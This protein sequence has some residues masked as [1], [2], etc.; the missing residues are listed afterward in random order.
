MERKRSLLWN[1]FSHIPNNPDAVKCDLC[2][3]TYSTKG[4]SSTNLKKHLMTRHRPSYDNLFSS[5][6]PITT[7]A[8]T[9]QP[10][11]PSVSTSTQPS[12]SQNHCLSENVEE[13]V[14]E[15]SST[16]I[17]TLSLPGKRQ[18]HISTFIKQRFNVARE[19]KINEL[20]MKMVVKDLQPL[21]VVEDSG[22]KDLVNFLEPNYKMPSRYMLS[23]S[24]LDI[25]FSFV[26]ERLNNE[27]KEAKYIALTT[28]GWTSRAANSY[29]A[30]TAHYILKESWELRSALL[31][32]FECQER[33][34]AEYL[35]NTIR[36]VT[37]SFDINEK[38]FVCVTDNAANMKAAVRLGGWEHFP[39]VAHTLN[40]MVRTG[41]T[42][43]R[44]ILKKIKAIV[45][46]FHRSSVAT[47][48]LVEIQEQLRPGQ[49]PL[50]M[51]LDVVTRW[52][53]TLDMIERINILQEPLG[54]A[55]GLL[56]N[57][58]PNLTEEEWILLPELI[59]ILKPFK[60]LTE[61]VSSQ[62][63]VSISKILAATKSVKRILNALDQT[64]M[65]SLSKDLVE[66]LIREYNKR[67]QNSSFHPILSKAALLDPRFKKASFACDLSYESGEQALQ[68]ELEQNPTVASI[69]IN[70]EV[71]SDPP[72]FRTDEPD[73]LWADFDTMTAASSSNIAAS[74]VSIRQYMDEKNINRK[75]NPLLWWK[76]RKIL[77]PEL[78]DLALKYLCIP[79]SSVPSERIFSKSGQILSE[80]RASLKPKR[81]EKILFLNVNQHLMN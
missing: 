64:A 63:E 62:K 72:T 48:K 22:F 56:H 67:F 47:K 26:K 12:T 3:S 8:P 61:E 5:P 34:T 70:T 20:I 24:L 4:G 49:K 25:Q 69:E 10:S 68:L 55:I 81:M 14:I 30:V 21:S 39:C 77:Y 76:N 15:S 18:T 35:K 46:H 75:E 41:L 79:A 66:T 43:V 45:E 60:E 7:V 19:K 17:S 28:D 29:Q 38:I 37:D 6:R 11:E 36:R 13:V 33:H 16:S 2:L 42:V 57:P 74:V 58:V 40:L 52:N 9:E 54:A 31:G 73:S 78:S 80:K 59:K 53:S 27:L 1:F 65:E 32:C 23:N 51:I 71:S 44:D 50:K